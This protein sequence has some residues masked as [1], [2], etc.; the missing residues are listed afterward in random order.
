MCG[1]YSCIPLHC[2]HFIVCLSLSCDCPLSITT[3]ATVFNCSPGS[4]QVDIVR[5]EVFLAIL[6][7]NDIQCAN[8][9]S[10]ED[11]RSMMTCL[12]SYTWEDRLGMYESSSISAKLGHCQRKGSPGTMGWGMWCNCIYFY[13]GLGREWGVPSQQT[14]GYEVLSEA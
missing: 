3:L 11:M 9:G 12:V 4:R 5:S 14:L 8:E 10:G 13:H 1:D 7:W 6:Y 2:L